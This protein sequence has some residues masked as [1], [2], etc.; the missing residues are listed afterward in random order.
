MEDFK[1]KVVVITGGAS[2]IGRAMANRFAAEG[3]KLV[4][5]DLREDRL[6]AVVKDLIGKG[7]DAHYKE[8]DV[9]NL[10]DVQ[11]L[12]DYAWNEFGHVDVLVN[13]AGIAGIPE[14]IVDSSEESFQRTFKT[15]AIGP[16]NGIW[17]FGKR[18][19]DQG[20]PAKIL[21]VC[22]ET[23]LYAPGPMTGIYAASKF[24]VRAICETLRMEVPEYIHVGCIYPGMVQTELGGTSELT[25]AGMSADEFINKVWPQIENNEFHIVSHP[26]GG[27]Y[28]GESAEEIIKAFDRYAP[29]YEG[30]NIYDSRSLAK[31]LLDTDS[32]TA[33]HE[34]KLNNQRAE[35][36]K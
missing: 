24:A 7:V 4:I 6:Q 35:S 27:D 31:Q 13:N 1:D 14:L 12:A 3:A 34:R 21:T 2:G 30:D 22:S 17:A 9:S 33:K 16:L 20:T 28:V 11:A 25:K 5:C 36:A 8:C 26:Y 15:N 19:I 10:K 32:Y 23:G 18:I 29:H